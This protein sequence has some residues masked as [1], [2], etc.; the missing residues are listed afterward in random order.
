MSSSLLLVL[1]GLI[2][3]GLLL[4]LAR[5][6]ALYTARLAL[7]LLLKARIPEV[8][9]EAISSIE[10]AEAVSQEETTRMPAWARLLIPHIVLVHYAWGDL[11]LVR[12]VLPLAA[13]KLNGVKAAVG[14]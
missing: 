4:A 1:F 6:R 5:E 11:Q 14:E 8:S 3:A 10:V 7:A 9:L 2:I 13:E 12:Q